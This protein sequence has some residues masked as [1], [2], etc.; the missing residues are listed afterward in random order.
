METNHRRLLTNCFCTFPFFSN[1]GLHSDKSLSSSLYRATILLM[2]V[3]FF[4][5]DQKKRKNRSVGLLAIVSLSCT[6]IYI[7]MTHFRSI[8]R[9]PA[10]EGRNA[11]NSL[12]WA[13]S[14]RWKIVFPLSRWI[15][16]RVDRYNRRGWVLSILY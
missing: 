16:G 3:S 4:F 12:E 10:L 14:S 1:L 2:T 7:Y 8:I 5:D 6:C 13:E 15:A 11:E 9:N